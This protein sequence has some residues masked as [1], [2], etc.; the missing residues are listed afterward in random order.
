MLARFATL[1][2][3]GAYTAAYRVVDMVMVPLNGLAAASVPRFFRAGATGTQNSVRYALR[4][5]P[6]PFLYI[7]FACTLLFSLAG[8]LPWILGSN[9]GSAVLPLRLLAWLPVFT[10]PRQFM[11]T[12]MLTSGHQ[13]KAVI[14]I[15]CGA[16]FNIAINLWA[17]PEWG[18]KG[19]VF[20]TYVAEMIMGCIMLFQI[21]RN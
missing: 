11:Q 5:F 1:E 15:V 2:A 12:I 13:K 17:I 19:A 8:V 20:A 18:W 3:A 16:I 7:L 14:V 9:Y 6:L 21:W 10:M 4:I